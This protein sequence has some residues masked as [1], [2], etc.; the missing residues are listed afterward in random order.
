MRLNLHQNYQLKVPTSWLNIKL[1]DSG[2]ICHRYVRYFTPFICHTFPAN[3]NQH[4][5]YQLKVPTSWLN[6]KLTD[7]GKICHRYVR[8][9]TPFICHTFPANTNL[10][11]NYQL[12]VPTSWL[13]IKLTDNG[14]S[15]T[16][17]SDISHLSFVT[18]FL[19]TPINIRT[20]S[21]KCL[22]HD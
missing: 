18:P 2:K 11:Q 12:K 15:F 4:Q 8:Y 1:T 5:N 3:T 7:S 10:H 14:R 19:L 17:M 6:I 21:W 22:P 16:G 13:N 20:I 9:F